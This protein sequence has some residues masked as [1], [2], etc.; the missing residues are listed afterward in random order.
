MSE[1]AEW[2]RKAKKESAKTPNELLYIIKG[3]SATLRFLAAVPLQIPHH[4]VHRSQFPFVCPR[5]LDKRCPFPNESEF[6][7]A[8]FS[9]WDYKLKLQRIFRQKMTKYSC[10]DDLIDIDVKVGLTKCDVQVDRVEIVG[11][12][13]SRYK[14]KVVKAKLDHT[15][16]KAFTKK[17]MIE[18]LKYEPTLFQALKEALKGKTGP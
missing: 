6:I 15:L 18:I 2:Y 3:K 7:M 16:P 12:T 5:M 13:K 1:L 10:I 17:E 14:A 11:S 9:V 4:E 8:C